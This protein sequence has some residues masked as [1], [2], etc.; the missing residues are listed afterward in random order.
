MTMVILFPIHAVFQ[1]I[2][3]CLTLHTC[4]LNFFAMIEIAIVYKGIALFLTWL[5]FSFKGLVIVNIRPGVQLLSSA[6][7]TSSTNIHKDEKINLNIYFTIICLWCSVQFLDMPLPINVNEKIM[8][9]LQN[10]I[11]WIFF[12]RMQLCAMVSVSDS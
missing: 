12:C 10:L 4:S 3:S 9:I 5:F 6:H 2:L 8:V 7:T 11:V 1:V